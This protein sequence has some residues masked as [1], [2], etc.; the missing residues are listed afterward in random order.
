MSLLT[1]LRS[2]AYS[3]P[4]LRFFMS[5]A[6]V[7]H[8]PFLFPDHFQSLQAETW[9]NLMK[10]LED[11]DRDACCVRRVEYCK[12]SNG[13]K[14]EFLAVH[15]YHCH[16]DR[17]AILIVDRTP[18]CTSEVDKLEGQS[19]SSGHGAHGFRKSSSRAPAHDQ[20]MVH[21]TQDSKSAGMRIFQPY[22]LLATLSFQSP[23]SLLEFAVLL[24]VVHQH[25]PYYDV[26][27]HQCYWYCDTIWRAL[28]DSKYGPRV[29]QTDSYDTR[30]K[31]V[32]LSVGS[33]SLG[34]IKLEFTEAMVNANADLQNKREQAEA[35]DIRV[36]VQFS[37]C[38]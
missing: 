28:E 14:H 31:Y 37:M 33:D 17:T 15:I 35:R 10:A 25:A 6:N 24:I 4:F 30:G 13:K 29:V 1:R 7:S 26:L 20:V 16:S 23:P 12:C 11:D 18:D 8:L 5:Y 32:L 36:R 9:S 22:K 2:L 34:S 38:D 19:P 27:Q 21:G 3:V